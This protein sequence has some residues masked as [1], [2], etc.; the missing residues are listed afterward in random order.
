[1]VTILVTLAFLS[2]NSGSGTMPPAAYT[3]KSDLIDDKGIGGWNPSLNSSWTLKDVAVEAKGLSIVVKKNSCCG[4]GGS[5]S[6]IVILANG[7]PEPVWLSACDSRLNL[8]REARDSAGVWR[9]IEYRAPS[10]CLNSYHLVALGSNRAW[11]WDVPATTGSFATKCRYVLSG[12]EKPVVSAEFDAKIDPMTFSVPEHWINDF[13]L[14][15]DGS[16]VPKRQ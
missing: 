16:L 2:H 10:D 5:C 8:G 12:L 4:P 1:M 14:K 7:T 9:P 11:T 6:M 13:E 3:A 15:S